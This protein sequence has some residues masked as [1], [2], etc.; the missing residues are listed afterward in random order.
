MGN[1]ERR[2]EEAE[3]SDEMREWDEVHRQ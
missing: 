2:R 1:L 3:E